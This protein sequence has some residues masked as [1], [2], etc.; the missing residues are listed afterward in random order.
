MTR[1][2]LK[3]TALTNANG[4][5]SGEQLGQP[6]KCLTQFAMQ[7]IFSVG[8]ARTVNT[9]TEIWSLGIMVYVVCGAASL[10]RLFLQSIISTSRVRNIDRA[11]EQGGSVVTSFTAG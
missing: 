9:W 2:P 3:N 7:P 11:K 1:W 10:I 8:G 6:R 4:V 5:G